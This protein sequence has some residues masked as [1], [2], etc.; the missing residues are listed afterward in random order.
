LTVTQYLSHAS[1]I[2]NA[3]KPEEEHFLICAKGGLR[4]GSILS[5]NSSLRGQFGRRAQLLYE[6]F[7]ES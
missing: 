4:I 5:C 2:A 1:V 6:L 3:Y 7:A